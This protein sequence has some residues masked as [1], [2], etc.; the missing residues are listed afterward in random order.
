MSKTVGNLMGVAKPASMSTQGQSD[1]LNYLKGVDTSNYDTVLKNLTDYASGASQNLADVLGNYNFNVNASDEARNQAQE[2][3][4]NSYLNYLQPKFEQQTSDLATALQ[5]KGFAVGSEAYQRA[6]GDLQDNQNQALN[7]ASYNAVLAGQNAYTQDLQNQIQASQFGNQAQQ[8]YINQLLSALQGSKSSYDIN[9]E[10]YNTQTAKDQIRQANAQ[11]KNSYNAAL[12]SSLVN[13]GVTAAMMFSD[14]RL[15]KNIKQIDEV[16]GFKIYS[17]EY[18]G[19]NTK[20]IGVMA[21]DM[22]NI[23][24]DSVIENFNGTKYLGV[25]YSKLPQNVREVCNVRI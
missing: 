10:I 14:K 7:Q 24:P 20:H 11:N 6:M 15:K 21:Q 18:K 16:D 5:N 4:Y 9:S 2:A 3:T 1:F 25:D 23:C 13:T 8:D 17:Y 19:D 22:Q 12:G